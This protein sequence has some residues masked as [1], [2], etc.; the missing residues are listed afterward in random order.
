[1]N[2]PQ[3]QGM[4]A[5]AALMLF[6]LGEGS[7][8]CA[9][10]KTELPEGF[11]L[12]QKSVQL[13]AGLGYKDNVTLSSFDRQD[14]AFE[15]LSADAMLFR[16][17]W[18]NWQVSL[19][20]VGSDTRYLDRSILV[21]KE[22]NAAVSGEFA[23]FLGRGWKSLSTLQYVF[24]N[25][26]MDVSTTYG[27]SSPQ[28]VFGHLLSFKE[29][30]RKDAGAWWAELDLSGVRGW[31][32]E[33]L[34]DYWQAGPGLALGR[35][36]GHDSEIALSYQ[37]SPL[38]YDQREQTDLAGMPLLD[39]RLRYMTQTLELA[40]RQSLDSRS[41]WCNTLR[42]GLEANRDNGAG[43]YD[44]TQYRITEQIRFRAAGWDLSALAS[45]VHYEFPRQP[46]S[47]DDTRSRHRT[48]ILVGL[49]GEKT[50]SQRWRVYVAY[51]FE[52]SLSNLNLDRYK[53][54]TVSGGV[55]FAF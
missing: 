4:G 25:Q 37:L 47:L 7:L 36:H 15:T 30:A 6:S 52:Q 1:M 55:A 31:F 29:G 33:P 8:L 14:S 44:Y 9:S 28:Q 19:M 53:A 38:T 12:W 18:N 21:D 42:L 17:P 45:A 54:N 13:R 20:A 35:R 22:Q 26:V 49:R 2:F 48:S 24:L 51:D 39:T 34:D 11:P 16:L 40:W 5:V 32:R 23:W 43:Y 10:E 46:I 50:L 41:R 3:G 27:A